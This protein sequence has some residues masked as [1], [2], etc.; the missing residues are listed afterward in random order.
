MKTYRLEQYD[1][2]LKKLP[3]AYIR[4]SLFSEGYLRLT[5]FFMGGGGLFSGG[6]IF[7]GACYRNF[8]VIGAHTYIYFFKSS[9]ELSL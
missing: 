8:T 3:W 5:F 2:S 6:L 7:E 4:E 1:D 9:E